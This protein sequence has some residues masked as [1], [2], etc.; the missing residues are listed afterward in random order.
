MQS[1]RDTV[2]QATVAVSALAAVVGSFIGS[3]AAGG[4][5]IQDAAGG[6]LS[7]SATPIAPAAPA[8]SIW[9][10]IYLGLIAYAIWQFLPTHKADAR[11]RRLGYWVAGSLLLNAAWILS[12][13]VGLLAL[14]ALL[15]VAL[16]AVLVVAFRIASVRGRRARRRTRSWLEVLLVD[17]TIGLYLGWVCVAT[18]ANLTALLVADGFDGFGFDPDAWAVA[19]IAVTAIVGVLLAIDDGGR[20]APALSLCWGLAWIAVG[21][22]AGSPHSL[23]AAISAIVAVVVIAV[24]TIV[25]RI[26]DRPA[27]DGGREDAA[28]GNSSAEGTSSGGTSSG[29]TS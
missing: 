25:F 18:A 27:R 12:V 24:A 26:L 5:P 9:S 28:S 16:L 20:I 21:R 7:A 17:G 29:A 6:A 19:V 13:Q 14:S 4:T 1:T 22:L 8:F 11:G 15:I 10:L 2:R 3:G 23:P